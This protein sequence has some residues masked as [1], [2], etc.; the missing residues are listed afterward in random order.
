[1]R[2][3]HRVDTRGDGRCFSVEEVVH[4]PIGGM[5]MTLDIL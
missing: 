1:M 4:C 3:L 5:L 2:S